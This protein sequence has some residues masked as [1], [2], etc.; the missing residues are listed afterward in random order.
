MEKEKKVETPVVSEEKPKKKWPHIV[1]KTGLIVGIV[2]STIVTIALSYVGYVVLSY[3]RI[4]DISLDVDNNSTKE[5]VAVNQELGM[6]T[7]NIGFGAYS[8]DFTFFLD[9]GYDDE[10][11]RTIGYHSKAL[12]K[13]DVI[14]NTNGAIKTVQDLNPDFVMLQEVDTNSTRSYHINQ[15]EEFKTSFKD[16]SHT[17]CVNFHTAFLPYPLYDMHGTVNAGLSTFSRYKIQAAERK[18]YTIADDLSKLFDL[19]RCFSVHEITVENGKSLFI[20]NSHMSAYDEGGVI[21]KQQMLELNTF[22]KS[23][24]DNGNYLIVGG[25]FN[26]DLLINNPDY[27][28]NETDHRPFGVTKK[29]PDWLSYLFDENGKSP[30]YDDVKVYAADNEP[31]CRNNDIEWEE[32]KTFVATVDGF[33]VSKNVEVNAVK[34]IRTKQGKK[35][36]DGFAF[37]DHQPVELRFTLK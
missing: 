29:K 24:T 11:N 18:S 21:R 35:G 10:G 20:I 37:S 6:V 23:V 36:V 12:S 2:L 14:F 19:D 7:Y 34:T 3:N 5:K 9:D 1:R 32:G 26:H 28:Y 8:Q 30:L 4:G 33:V 27:N 17:H 15:D 16:Y 25:D 31:T 22:M 13:D